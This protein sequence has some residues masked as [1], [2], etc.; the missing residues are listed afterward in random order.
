ML[1]RRHTALLTGFLLLLAGFV[2]LQ[3]QDVD[4]VTLTFGFPAIGQVYIN[5]V[6]RGNQPLI[7]AGEIL[8]LLYIPYERTGNNFG[9][10]GSYP[11][12]KDVWE[13]DPVKLT[14]IRKGEKVVLNAQ[15]FYLGETDLYLTPDLFQQLFDIEL[16]VNSYGLMLSLRS[17][18]ILP[19]EER[20]KRQN[21][22]YQLKQQA[23]ENALKTY[24]MLYPRK[25]AFLAPGMLDYNLGVSTA[26][27]STQYT[28]TLNAGVEFLGGDMQ[29]GLSGFKNEGFS[30]YLISGVRWRYV[31]KGGLDPVGNPLISELNLGQLN[32]GGPL[33]GRVKG[34]SLTNTPLIPRRVLDL[35]AIEGNTV[36]D[37]EV[38]LLIGG[39]LVD[40]VRADE[41]GYYRFTTPITYG[42]VRIGLR[43]YT[44]QGEVLF[45]DRQLQIPFTFVPRGVV[46]YN[47]QA[48]FL[49]LDTDS[50]GTTPVA[51]GD[52]AYGLT[53]NIT[54]RAGASRGLDSTGTAL[55]PYGSLSARL[56][57]QYLLNVEA[58]P[59]RF[60]RGSASV[61]YANNTSINAQYTTFTGISTLNPL[62][63]QREANFNFFFPMTVLKRPSGIRL[64]LDHSWYYNGTATRYQVDLNTR[65]GQI[66]SRINYREELS[67]RVDSVIAPK[68]LITGAFTYTVP[69][70]PGVPV[71]VRGMFFRTQIRHDMKRFDATA[72]GSFQFS[73]TVLKRGRITLGYEHDFVQSTNQFQVGFLYD[74]NAVR[75]SSQAT[76]RQ[77]GKLVNPSF[78]QSFSGSF[79]ADFRNSAIIPTNRDQ[80]GRAG[81][82]VRMFIDENSNQKYDKG[83][84]IIP[85][86]AV[87]LDQSSSMLIG[88]DG[89]LRISQLQ[90][91]WTYKLTIDINAL[92]DPNLA[93]LQTK[94]SF[95]ADPNRYKQIDI[96]MYRTGSI[97]GYAFRERIPGANLEP[98]AGL[99]LY[100]HR[101]GDEAPLDPIRTF[102]DGGFYAFGLLPGKY[103]LLVDSGQLSF[104]RVEQVPDTVR[105]TIRPL[106]EGDVVDT[107]EIRLVPAKDDTLKEDE[108]LTLAQL[109]FQ[110]G[111]RLKNSVTAFIEA[112]EL[113]Y[114]G[115]YKKALVMVDS[116]MDQF[117]TDFALALKGS[118]VFL[119]GNKRQAVHLW[120]EARA[121][122]PFVELPD[123]A[124]FRNMKDTSTYNP[125]LT[126]KADTAV[127][128]SAAQVKA[129]LMLALENKLS[130]QLQQSVTAFV[131]A[132]ELFYRR[133][134]AEAGD[135]VDAS[136]SLF[137]TDHG[138]ALKGSIAYI[139]GRRKDA[140]RLWEEARER[141]PHIVLPDTEIL[142]R[143][144]TPIT[145]TTT[146][147]GRKTYS[148]NR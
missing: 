122:N 77:K 92:P 19:V 124:L 131:E 129:A 4:E 128:D 64:G 29:G 34:M 119:L 62:A 137:V 113:F 55:Q 37:S 6:F 109:E 21:L 144:I 47:I 48:G 97:E 139:T 11:T 40:F 103:T 138:L 33:G 44:P 105:F 88:S 9:L 25:R 141:N 125:D 107:L 130:E 20:Q 13:V 84:E 123:T 54:F 74:F 73:Q 52:V 95:T 142:D 49:E 12:K 38:E 26:S 86:K 57:E 42:T 35:F 126:V 106:A 98:Q 63:Q 93:P 80:V 58:L 72:L 41:L 114:R 99:R 116:S 75:S 43:I 132:Q 100:L 143:M 32:L 15:Q 51:H 112:Q 147:N 10:K 17:E 46:N 133:R 53:N 127:L 70:N 120:Q 118:V 82:T 24:P 30:D 96:P 76:I 45:E 66:I 61:F 22:R 18:R 31:F 23:P 81:A 146:K 67:Q 28:Y 68:R 135:K 5:A 78:N 14:L 121:R 111:Q 16:T 104:M 140:W 87:R 134:F 71:F 50:F 2:P 7:A 102:S 39:Q 83:E 115:D 136:L 90:S 108:P 110:L 69:R 56:F 8:G 60:V 89:M 65:I 145:E 101:E 148:L 85:A 117:N 27:G 59:E 1:F 79:A 91:Y 36:P 94:F 3:A